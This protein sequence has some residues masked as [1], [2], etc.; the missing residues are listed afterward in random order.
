M[1]K[2][3]SARR[4]SPLKAE[5]NVGILRMLGE[6]HTQ[7]KVAKHF[8]VSRNAVAAVVRRAKDGYADPRWKT[9]I[10]AAGP[11]PAPIIIDRATDRQ[12]IADFIARNGVKKCPTVALNPTQAILQPTPGIDDRWNGKTGWPA[13]EGKTSP[14]RRKLGKG[15][16]SSMKSCRVGAVI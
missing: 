13:S 1:N 10:A 8:Q 16:A 6:G 15:G 2:L 12:M 7:T 5:R 11:I 3:V 9:A 14:R 4:G